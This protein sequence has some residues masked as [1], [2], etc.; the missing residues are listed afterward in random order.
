MIM[1]RTGRNDPC[2]CGSGKRYKQC[3]GS[4]AEEVQAASTHA[5]DTSITDAIRDALEHH[6]AGRLPQ[7][8]AIYR[9]VLQVAPNHPDA[10]HFLGLIA[11]QTGNND[12]A[13]ELI[14]KAISVIPSSSMYC[15]LGTALRNQGKL[16]AAVESYHRAL[17]ITP[18]YAEAHYNLGLVLR[19]QN[20]LDAA[21]ESYRKALA[22][23]PDF[24]GAYGNLGTA[25]NDQGKLDAAVECYRKALAINP[26][27]AEAHYNLGIAFQQQ[28]R[29][30]AA[31]ESYRKALAIKPDHAAA[32]DALGIVL[33]EQ[34]KLDAAVESHRKA[35]A[36]NPY[37][38]E[39]HYN[40][41]IALQ[42]QMKLDLAVDSYRKALAIKPDYAEAYSNLGNALKDQGK[43]DAALESYRKAL[44]IKPNYA[45]AHSN[46]LMTAQ[47]GPDHSPAELFADHLAFAARFEAP[48]R[49]GWPSHDNNRDIQ[50]RLKIG[51]VSG[52]L[53]IHPVGIF[54]ECVLAHL[55]PQ[56]LDIVLY[57]T[58]SQVDALSRRLQAMGFAWESLVG[59]SDEHAAQRIREDAID[60]LVDLSGHTGHNR[61]RLFA[62]K[63][64][65]VQV[66]WLGY[67]A[68]TGLQ[69]MDYILCDRYAV[70]PSES[71]QFVETPWYLPN[72]YLC[73]SP[74]Q[75]EVAIRAPPA[76]TQGRV[77]FGSFNNLAKMNDAVV[78]LWAQVLQAVPGSGL[79]LKA[80]S[81]PTAISSCG[82]VKHRYALGRRHGF[83]TK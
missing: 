6:Q 70:P 14:S 22:V 59:I 30:D 64:A 66:T 21:V 28:V 54:L 52:D 32:H 50:R 67:P 63:P 48:L 65:P 74:L 58:H 12:T 41:G 9:Q 60:I 44:S 55:D 3:C 7:A 26:E 73:L 79:L 25:L 49:A 38:A 51:F 31:V 83:S 17:S 71:G 82:G 69:A 19:Q 20:K 57:P 42:Q 53:C 24:A 11:H 13:V 46:Y 78:A 72:T 40:L 76:L 18:D 1:Q 23:N 61:L 29:L 62:R 39:A 36:I 47:Y 37:F 43:L 33:Q 4:L 34:G 10:L 81:A 2:P 80:G 75:D 8:E 35:L 77:T 45:D 27:F 68:T 5:V 56:A 16:D 15:N